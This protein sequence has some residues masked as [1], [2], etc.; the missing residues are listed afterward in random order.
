MESSSQSKDK[1]K[2]ERC[3]EDQNERRRERENGE[4]KE[5]GEGP[6]RGIRKREKELLTE[7]LEEVVELLSLGQGQLVKYLLKG[8]VIEQL[9]L[10]LTGET[11]V[12]SSG[13]LMIYIH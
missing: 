13:V 9:L 12:V 5:Q 6:T 10:V 7:N 1:Y 2:R 3:Q 11:A 8:D 4:L